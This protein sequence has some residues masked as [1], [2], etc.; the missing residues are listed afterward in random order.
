MKRIA[1][2]TFT[3]LTFFLAVG[4]TTVRA[5]ESARADENNDKVREGLGLRFAASSTTTDSTTPASTPVVKS[6]DKR[7][8]KKF[9][10]NLAIS[11]ATCGIGIGLAANPA[12]AAEVGLPILF[13]GNYLA[14]R[15]YRLHPKLSGF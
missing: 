7:P 2:L 13:G 12:T 3:L 14:W 8:K 1:L 10:R 9:I 4:I 11:A 15:L 5:D 6:T